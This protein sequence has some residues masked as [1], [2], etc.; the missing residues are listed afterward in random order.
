ML[1]TRKGN[2]T[3]NQSCALE[4]K[5]SGEFEK[6]NKRERVRARSSLNITT[7]GRCEIFMCLQLS[8]ERANEGPRRKESVNAHYWVCLVHTSSFVWVMRRSAH[9]YTVGERKKMNGGRPWIPSAIAF[10]SSHCSPQ[11]RFLI[12]NQPK[13]CL[14]GRGVCEIHHDWHLFLPWDARSFL[15]PAPGSRRARWCIG[16]DV[17]EIAAELLPMLEFESTADTFIDSFRQR[18]VTAAG[19]KHPRSERTIYSF[20]VLDNWQ[21]LN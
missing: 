8:G 13:T 20:N 19:R 2:A 18:W 4:N 11:S 6:A 9:L 10:R 1:Q 14:A 5:F 3:L 16:P 17:R 15:P 21:D 7:R 12:R